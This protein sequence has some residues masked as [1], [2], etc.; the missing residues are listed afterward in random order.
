MGV[1]T[2]LA[3]ASL[4][5]AA[6]SAYVAHKDTVAA[7]KQQQKASDVASAQ[8]RVKQQAD[9]RNQIRQQRIRTAQIMQASSN[10]GTAGSSG[11]LGGVAA[12]GSQVGSNISNIQGSGNSQQAILGYENQAQN[13]LTRASTWSAVGQLASSSFNIF[14]NTP[15]YRDTMNS[16]FA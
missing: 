1:A 7:R 12:L 9:I 5:V 8:N 15:G 3:I 2:V 11:S 10:S 16:V 4:V 13:E 6:G 14:S